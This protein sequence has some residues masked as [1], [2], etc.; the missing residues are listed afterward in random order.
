MEFSTAGG[1]LED[2]NRNSAVTTSSHELSGA[3]STGQQSLKHATGRRYSF[4]QTS[5]NDGLR[6]ILK[7]KTHVA[8]PPH[9]VTIGS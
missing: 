9:H 3:A 2:W 7:R 5:D 4:K 8:M 6:L 1:Q